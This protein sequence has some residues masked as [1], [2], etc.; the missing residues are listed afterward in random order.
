MADH[1]VV[2]RLSRTV[3]RRLRVLAALVAAFVV[4][5]AGAA[6]ALDGSETRAPEIKNNWTV[7]GEVWQGDFADPMVTRV[8]DTYYAYA[9]NT[10]GRYVPALTSTDLVTWRARP[11]YSQ[12]G[13]PGKPG[14]SVASDASIPAEFRA[15]SWSDWDKFNNNDVLVQPASWGLKTSDGPWVRTEYWAPSAFQIGDTWYLYSAVRV[16]ATRFCITM[17][18][19]PGPLGPFRDTTTGPVQCQPVETDPDGSI[20]PAGYHDPATGKDYLLWKALGKVNSHPSALMSVELGGDGLPKPGAPWT[21]LLTT[22]EGGWEGTTI[23]NPSMVSYGGTTYLFYSAN[24]WGTTDAAGRS[25]YATGYAICPQG[26]TGPCARPDEK[27]LLSS[28]GTAQGPGG[29]AAFLDAAGNLRIASATYFLGEDRV[30]EAIRHPRR[31]SIGTLARAADGRLSVVAGTA[32]V[33]PW[34]PVATAT[35]AQ[36]TTAQPAPPAAKAPAKAPAKSSA[37][38]PTKKPSVKKKSAAKKR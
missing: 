27:P 8:G 36:D 10:A 33:G 18:T 19:G 17:A 22:H 14:Y 24:H 15:Q 11:T 4:V 16:G 30:G 3:P 2:A 32:P 9:T 26:P 29:S 20:D 34:S 38:K 12:A 13:P 21:T 6:A 5:P 35:R 1:Q 37:K 7:P 31:L 25:N 23:E 28:N